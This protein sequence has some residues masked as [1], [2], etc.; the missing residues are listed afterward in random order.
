M[1]RYFL[2]LLG[3]VIICGAGCQKEFLDAKPNKALLVPET[4][5]DFQALLDNILLMNVY[6]G[7]PEIASDEFDLVEGRLSRLTP[8]AVQSGAHFWLADAYQ[9][10]AVSDWNDGYIQVFYSNVVL[11][12]LKNIA[13][14]ATNQGDYNRVKGSALFYRAMAMYNL[15]QIFAKPYDANA[16]N[17]LGLPYPIVSD[18]NE[19][20]GRKTLA[21]SYEQILKDLNEAA[22]LLPLQAVTKNRAGKH[23]TYAL[24]ARVYLSMKDY[25]HA[26]VFASKALAIN[27]KLINYNTAST[28]FARFA[29]PLP[30]GNDEV[31]FYTRKLAYTFFSRGILKVNDNLLPLYTTTND[32]RKSVNFYG[33]ASAIYFAGYQGL[34]TDEMMLIHAECR[35]RAGDVTSALKD[36]NTLL[37]TRWKTGTYIPMTAANEEVALK[38]VLTERR[39]EIVGRGLRWADLRRLNQDPRFAVNLSRVYGGVT[40]TLPAN[41]KRYTFPI[42]DNEVRESGIEQNER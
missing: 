10:N 40:Y 34:C 23:S 6:P 20:P 36:I 8:V 15:C 38:V 9:G 27:S 21:S 17:N 4:L 37:I 16:I 30:N 42:P 18:V 14:T 2:I 26:E 11:D 7:I 3:L 19:R 1:K 31:I 12:G 5:N 33:T 24:L 13:S 29:E 39:K 22:D 41:D 28:A 25:T 32:L 35:A